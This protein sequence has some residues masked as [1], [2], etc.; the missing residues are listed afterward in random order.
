MVSKNI[1]NILVAICTNC[2]YVLKGAHFCLIYQIFQS[3]PP[4]VYLAFISI[5]SE[6]FL[7]RKRDFSALKL[8]LT[9]QLF[10]C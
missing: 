1:F 3:G 4:N 8:A 5:R 6:M 7:L 10:Q 9:I 2:S